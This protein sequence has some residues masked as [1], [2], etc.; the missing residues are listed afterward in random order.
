MFLLAGLV[1]GSECPHFRTISE[2]QDFQRD[3]N[4][5]EATGNGYFLPEPLAQHFAELNSEIGNDTGYNT[6]D[7]GRD[8]NGH[9]KEGETDPHRQCI[10]ADA[11]GQCQEQYPLCGVFSLCFLFFNDGIPNHFNTYAEEQDKGD[12]FVPLQEMSTDGAAGQPSDNGIDGLE[13]AKMKVDSKCL[14]FGHSSE[15]YGS[16]NG[17]CQRIHS[18]G[19]GYGQKS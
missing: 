8:D 9:S 7:D 11:G 6:N 3:G 10:N 18:K 4:K 14:P 13:E 5:D 1:V 19:N 17:N 12:D 2:K 15:K 16:G